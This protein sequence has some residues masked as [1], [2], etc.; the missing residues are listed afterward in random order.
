[1]TLAPL[2]KVGGVSFLSTGVGKA[3]VLGLLL[4]TRG[5]RPMASGNRSWIDESRAH[6][7]VAGCGEV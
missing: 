2:Q 5:L 3:R 4:L 6:R 1:M 7:W